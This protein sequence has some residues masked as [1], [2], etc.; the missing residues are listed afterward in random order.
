M[1]VNNRRIDWRFN[2]LVKVTLA[3]QQV[4]VDA[5][6]RIRYRDC[7]KKINKIILGEGAD[8][9]A[10]QPRYVGGDMS[11][12]QQYQSSQSARTS[13][14]AEFIPMEVEI[15]LTPEETITSDIEEDP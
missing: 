7:G 1:A 13:A 10:Q 8:A 2:V 14:L 4:D 9:L 12:T 3:A 6:S 11:P 15:S 5:F